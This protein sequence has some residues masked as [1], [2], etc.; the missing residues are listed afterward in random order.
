MANRRKGEGQTALITGASSGIGLE[1]AR[2]FAEDGYNLV[3]VSHSAAALEAEAANSR[4]SLTSAQ[5][6]LPAI[7][8]SAMRA[9]SLPKRSASA[10][11]IS[12]LWSTTPAMERQAPST[13]AILPPS[14]V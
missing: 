6:T 7:S 13:E 14:L 5:L 1:L 8:A 9:Q 12:M 11:S 10:L 2:C 3:L 4:V